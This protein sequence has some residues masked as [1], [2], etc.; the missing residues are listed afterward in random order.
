MYTYECKYQ[1]S[2]RR[3][4]IYSHVHNEWIWPQGIHQ[5]QEIEKRATVTTSHPPTHGQNMWG[6]TQGCTSFFCP[7]VP[8][9]PKGGRIQGVG[10]AMG[11]PK[12]GKVKHHT[13][14]QMVVELATRQSLIFSLRVS[15]TA[16]ICARGKHEFSRLQY[17]KHKFTSSSWMAYAPPLVNPG[18]WEISRGKEQLHFPAKYP[19][20]YFPGK[21]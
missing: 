16:D 1:V 11:Q 4:S 5:R 9:H 19:S 20:H 2:Y 8:S 17:P 12:R 10:F 15:I 21:F 7:F 6:D 13:H 14:T 18:L 3:L